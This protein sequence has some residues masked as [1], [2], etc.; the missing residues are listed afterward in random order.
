MTPN[1]ESEMVFFALEEIKKK[2]N[3]SDTWYLYFPKQTITS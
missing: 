1:L 2:K 3:T